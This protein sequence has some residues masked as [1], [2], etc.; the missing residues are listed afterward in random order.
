MCFSVLLVPSIAFGDTIAEKQAEQGQIVKEI[1]ANQSKLD[2]LSNDYNDAL[3][4]LE[5]AEEQIK[6]LKEKIKTAQ[7]KINFNQKQ[8]TRQAINTYKNGN[9]PF[10]DVLLDSKDFDTFV[11]NL[12]YSNQVMGYTNNVISETKNLKTQLNQDKNK[13]EELKTVAK[14]EAAAAQTAMKQADSIIA[15]LEKEYSS[16]DQEIVELLVQEEIAA[17]QAAAQSSN[18][19]VYVGESNSNNSNNQSTTS[20]GTATSN[21]SSS[22]SGDSDVVSRAYSKIGS[23]YSW[24]GTTSSGFDCSGFVS[25]CLSGKEGTRL[26]TTATFSS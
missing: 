15:N 19:A 20:S 14:N 5:D 16:I 4:K 25:Y 22:Y 21:S 6:T 10:M 7:K 23:P 2:T 12:D 9:I 26:G 17:Q 18:N 3:I 8:L 24:G 11:T 13:Q 1:Q